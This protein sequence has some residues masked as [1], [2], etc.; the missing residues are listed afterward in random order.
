MFSHITSMDLRSV[1]EPQQ[2]EGVDVGS[3]YL[4]RKKCK[5]YF[6][7]RMVGANLQGHIA[8]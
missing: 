5:N 1:N 8:V 2:P 4:G 7:N 3:I 6:I